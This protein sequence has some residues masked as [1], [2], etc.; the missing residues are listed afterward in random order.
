M[1]ELPDPKRWLLAR[2]HYIRT[3]LMEITTPKTPTQEIAH[4][5]YIRRLNVLALDANTDPLD[6]K[7]V[8][9]KDLDAI[10]FKDFKASIHNIER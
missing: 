5:E 8:Y 7:T 3:L 4:R 6:T 9:R 1:S 10:G 2:I